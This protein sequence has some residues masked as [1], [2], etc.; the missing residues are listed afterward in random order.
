MKGNHWMEIRT[1]RKKGKL[2]FSNVWVKSVV[3]F[4]QT[5]V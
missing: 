4:S 5:T 1:E 3:L 2:T